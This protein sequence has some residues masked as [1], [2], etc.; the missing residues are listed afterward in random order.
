MSPKL[1][2][3]NLDL[4]IKKVELC[5]EILEIKYKDIRPGA[6]KSFDVNRA[7]QINLLQRKGK[8]NLETAKATG[9]KI[10][11]NDYNND[12]ASRSYYKYKRLGEKIDKKLEALEEYLEGL[13][14]TEE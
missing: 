7:L 14:K 3:S 8:T 2:V 4:F 12:I 5:K 11:K 10:Y 1:P 6:P 9:F 13:H